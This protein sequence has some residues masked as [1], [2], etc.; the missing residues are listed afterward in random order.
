MLKLQW[1]AG[2]QLNCPI[3]YSSLVAMAS[4]YFLEY[5][6]RSSMEWTAMAGSSILAVGPSHSNPLQ[7]PASPDFKSKSSPRSTSPTYTRQGL[8]L[9]TVLD[10]RTPRN[11]ALTTHPPNAKQ[12]L[13]SQEIAWYPMGNSGSI[14]PKVEKKY[15]KCLSE[16]H[17]SS[18]IIIGYF[19]V[20]FCI[21]SYA[22]LLTQTTLIHD[23][24]LIHD[25]SRINET[26]QTYR[27]FYNPHN[28]IFVS[29]SYCI[30]CINVIYNYAS[31]IA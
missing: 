28:L 18:H 27:L 23:C 20:S 15:V 12:H 7:V 1:A 2:Q 21:L 13:Y 9:S 16:G 26:E 14:P 4:L 24:I 19:N 17:Y 6:K 22:S 25:K 5:Q 11:E 3:R 31:N 30:I 10:N 8:Q 29:S